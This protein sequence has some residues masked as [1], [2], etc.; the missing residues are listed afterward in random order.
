MIELGHSHEYHAELVDDHEAES[1]AIHILD[2]H[3]KPISIAA[4]S[5]SLILTVGDDTQSFEL[6][7]QDSD[8]TRVFVSTESDLMKLLD[9]DGATGKLRV[10]IGDR[11]FSG[12]FSHQEHDHSHGDHEH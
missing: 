4:E 3:M 6:V 2:A 9:Q 12:T 7:S 11:P 8:G 10:T 5:I 1:I